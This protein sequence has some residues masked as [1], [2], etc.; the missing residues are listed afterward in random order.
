MMKL[1]I[2]VFIAALLIAE[3]GRAARRRRR[4]QLKKKRDYL[5]GILQGI[6]NVCFNQEN[7]VYT[8]PSSAIEQ[9]VIGVFA[10]VSFVVIMGFICII[11]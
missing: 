6:N 2:L 8:K 5:N 7:C 3:G 1:I 9:N 11:S 10:I 4:D